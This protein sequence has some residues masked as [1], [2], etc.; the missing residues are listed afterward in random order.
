MIGIIGLVLLLAASIFGFANRGTS[1]IGVP[2]GQRLHPFAAPLGNST[3]I[4]DPNLNP[5]CTSARHD[6]RALNVCLL[7]DRG[8][9]VLTFFVTSSPECV[10]EVNALQAVSARFRRGGVTFAALAVNA[11]RAA[12]AAL[13]R[14]HHWTIPVAYDRD[15][16]IGSVYGVAICPLT[17]M[18]YRGGVVQRRLVGDRW[19]SPSVLLPA[20][21]DL[22]Q[23][24]AR[25]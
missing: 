15:G 1:T 11:H 10:R 25:R 13:I 14:A 21:R 12:T 17:E 8:P 9:L 16:A 4:G 18:A 20:V 23:A 5:I 24:N 22:I 19:S 7:A 3:L 2:A 6:P